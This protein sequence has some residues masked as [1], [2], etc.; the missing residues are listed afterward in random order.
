MST[1]AAEAPSTWRWYQRRIADFFQ[2]IQGA[3]VKA[4]HIRGISGRMR[5]I[6]VDIHLPLNIA[7][8]NGIEVPID[9]HI[10]ADAKEY[11]RPVSVER[12]GSV[13]V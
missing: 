10:I 7:L 4:A 9:I 1:P 8:A 13:S 6:D 11:A 12:V 2:R 3:S 5:Q